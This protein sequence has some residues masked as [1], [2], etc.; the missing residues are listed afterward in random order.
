MYYIMSCGRFDAA[1]GKRVAGSQN[2]GKEWEG[3]KEGGVEGRKQVPHG[4]LS[5]LNAIS[6]NSKW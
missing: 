2:R 6:L 3:R 5:F 4:T 1:F